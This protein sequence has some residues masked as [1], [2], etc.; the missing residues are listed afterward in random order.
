MPGRLF[1]LLALTLAP[2]AA[3]A[4]EARG[5]LLARYSFEDTV[6]TGPDTLAVWQGARH[7]GT[8]QGSVALSTAFHVSGYRSVEIKDV[9][10]DGDFPE[11]QGYF[12]VRNAGAL[13]FHFAFLTT[14]AKEELNVALAG[15]RFFTLEKDGMAFWLG[16]RAGALVHVSGGTTRTLVPVEAFVWYVVDVAYHVGAGTYSL[17]VRREGQAA[18]LVHVRGQPNATARPGSAVD[19][20]SFVGSPLDDRSNV[21]YYVDD[22]VIGTDESVAEV[23]FVAPGRRKLF[24]DR[25]G[26]YQRLLRERPRACRP[27]PPRTWA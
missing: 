23:P 26:E 17:T 11:L 9:A 27:P 19:K 3:V 21:L 22:V 14:D 5:A 13:F 18:P 6:A 16:T 24:V 15:P 1:S 8:G 4:D 12:P 25:F 10:G 2:L 20:F 7:V